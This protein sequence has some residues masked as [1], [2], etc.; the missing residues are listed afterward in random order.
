[1]IELR[2]VLLEGVKSTVLSGEDQD[3]SQ[4]GSI[5]A[6]IIKNAIDRHRGPFEEAYNTALAKSSEDWVK[7]SLRIS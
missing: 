6:D 3:E 7:I 2:R 4:N 5:W 1:M